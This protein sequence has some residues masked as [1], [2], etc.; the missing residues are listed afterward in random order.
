MITILD[1]GL[2]NRGSIVN[3]LKKIGA[4]AIL[5]SRARDIQAAS[6]LIIPGVGAFDEGAKNLR[7]TGLIPTLDEQVLRK[8]VPVLGICLGLQLFT[9]DSEEGTEEGLGWIEGRTRKFKSNDNN[10]K[11]PHMGWNVIQIEQACKLFDDLPSDS[12]FYFVHSYYVECSNGRNVLATSYYGNQ[13]AAV[14]GHGNIYGV[15]FHPEKSHRFG[16]Q[17]LKNF[18]ELT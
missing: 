3:M 14:V 9:K 7:A 2:G 17:I 10:F 5:T 13:F 16:M 12:R 4:D 11:I 15:Q 1:Y 6:K 8:K 18:L